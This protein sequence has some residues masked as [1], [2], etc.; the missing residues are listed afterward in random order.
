MFYTLK[1]LKMRHKVL[2]LIRNPFPCFLIW[3]GLKFC[4]K[5]IYIYTKIRFLWENKVRT[6]LNSQYLYKPPSLYL[7]NI[8][9]KTCCNFKILESI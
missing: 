8:E 3:F 6:S 7:D 1:I 9:W 2:N 4:L 5:E